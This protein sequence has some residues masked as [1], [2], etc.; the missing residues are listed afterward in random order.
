MILNDKPNTED[1]SVDNKKLKV[2]VNEVAVSV[3][4]NPAKELV[5][6]TANQNVKQLEIY[7]IEGKLVYRGWPNSTIV[8]VDLTN[9]DKGLYIVNV[10]TAE[11]TKASRLIKE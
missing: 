7:T 5:N 8:S 4:P 3:Y 9:F 6:I 10:Y 11:Q 2:F 1:I